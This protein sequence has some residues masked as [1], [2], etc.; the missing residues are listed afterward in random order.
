MSERNIAS[1]VTLKYTVQAKNV[2]HDLDESR[3]RKQACLT[4]P[5]LMDWNP[6]WNALTKRSVDMVEISFVQFLLTFKTFLVE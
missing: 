2:Q 6:K 1:T 5:T 4:L 3:Q